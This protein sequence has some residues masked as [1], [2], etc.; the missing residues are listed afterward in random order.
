MLQK[1]EIASAPLSHDCHWRPIFD[2]Q[3]VAAI[4][5]DL[6]EVLSISTLPKYVCL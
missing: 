2:D 3:D 5:E 4:G 1:N 6:D